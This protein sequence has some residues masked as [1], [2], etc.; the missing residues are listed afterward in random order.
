MVYPY[1]RLLFGNKKE[2]AYRYLMPVGSTLKT[3]HQIKEVSYRRPYTVWFH[4]YE[5]F[6]KR[7]V[8]RGRKEIC[9]C[10]VL[11]EEEEWEGTPD[12]PVVSFQGEENLWELIIIVTQ[13]CENRW[14]PSSFL[15]AVKWPFNTQGTGSNSAWGSGEASDG[16]SPEGDP[17][18][19]RRNSGNQ[20]ADWGC[21]SPDP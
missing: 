17:Q 1:N 18:K 21:E 11:M 13:L 5:L 4:W 12:G 7:Q 10:Q 16:G 15:P 6:G 19:L 8:H 3:L 9:G 2:W 14:L 20:A